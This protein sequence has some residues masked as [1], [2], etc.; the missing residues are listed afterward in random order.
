[1]NDFPAT[2][3]RV[4]SIDPCGDTEVRIMMEMI[5][6]VNRLAEVGSDL[7]RAS[8]DHMRTEEAKRKKKHKS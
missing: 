4:V 7:L 3:V 1:M 6:D 5:A 8:I 2:R